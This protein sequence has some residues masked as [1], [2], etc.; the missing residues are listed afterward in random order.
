[1]SSS[2]QQ[3]KATTTTNHDYIKTKDQ[4]TTSNSRTQNK[5][6]PNVNDRFTNA[7]Q[8]NQMIWHIS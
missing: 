3:I 4:L 8:N 5:T 2:Q 7:N 6:K 1:M